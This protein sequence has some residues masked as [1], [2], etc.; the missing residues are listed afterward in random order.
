MKSANISVLQAAFERSTILTMDE[1]R[2]LC[3]GTTMRSIIRYLN[4]IGYYASYN[5]KGMYYTLAHIPKFDQF[6]LWRCKE[7]L[8]SSSGSLKDTIRFLVSDAEAGMT[9]DELASMLH[10]SA[11]N[12]LT[13]L[14]ASET[15]SRSK[16]L[17]VYVYYSADPAKKA[18]QEETR[19]GRIG[20]AERGSAVDPHDVVEVLI[21]YIKGIMT[22]EK[23]SA[24]L[25]HKGRNI[26]GSRVAAIFRHYDL[27][28]DPD[29]KKKLV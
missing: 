12:A 28:C 2:S 4:E 10:V 1:M 17:G 27:E 11:K 5:F 16:S 18:R 7:A 6:G 19:R 29:G 25:R 20:E 24:H 14:S 8:F 23:I 3:E 9:G 26:S 21:A 22:P 13:E 15:V